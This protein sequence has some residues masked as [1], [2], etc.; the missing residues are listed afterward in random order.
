MGTVARSLRGVLRPSVEVIADRRGRWCREGVVGAAEMPVMMMEGVLAVAVA[1]TPDG[2]LL[3]P[4]WVQLGQGIA[5]FNVNA[6][7][8][9]GGGF[10]VTA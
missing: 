9:K 3:D 1:L 2:L 8:P 4:G 6:P 7:P 5:W 10:G